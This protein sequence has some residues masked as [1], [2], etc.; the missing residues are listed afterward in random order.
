V[1]L[2]G[3]RF[4]RQWKSRARVTLLVYKSDT[5]QRVCSVKNMFDAAT[6]AE[7]RT[8]VA[9]LGPR[10]ER[11]WG[12][13]DLPQTLAHCSAGF[14][15]ATGEIRP[16]R[17]LIGR[18]LGWAI[19]PMA[20]GNDAPM[21]PD[22]PTVEELIVRDKRDFET[23]RKRLSAAIDQFVA[24]GPALCTTHPHPFFGRLTPAQ[25]AIQMYKHLDH[26]LRQFGG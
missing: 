17:V 1:P 6:A 23:E 8:R 5:S 12:R 11:Q 24:G 22:S 16:P 2:I 19:K 21:R 18:I 14:G 3:D 4:D 25:W 26:H 15:L 13:M 7:I 10:D 20:P 9:Q